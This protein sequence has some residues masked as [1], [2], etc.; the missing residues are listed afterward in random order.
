M[1]RQVLAFKVICCCCGFRVQLDSKVC[2]ESRADKDHRDR[3]DQKDPLVYRVLLY[4]N[5]ELK[6]QQWQLRKR[7]LKSEFA[8]LQT[9]SC[10]FHLVQFVK[11]WQIFLELNFKGLYQSSE[12]EKESRWL[13][14][15]SSTKHEI[16]QFHVVVVQR[17]QRNVQKKHDACSKMMFCQSKPTAFCRSCCCHRC[18]CLNSL[19]TL[20]VHF[21]LI[22]VYFLITRNIKILKCTKIMLLNLNRR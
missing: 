9:L 11:C 7:H 22:D 21:F 3:E 1:Q 5:R 18:H 13:V 14:F 20:S 17:R 8:L 16:R 6:Q 4:V 12:K 10:I 15:M 19:T 2:K